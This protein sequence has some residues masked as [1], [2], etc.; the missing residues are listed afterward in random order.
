[1]TSERMT[2]SLV[3]GMVVKVG[4][5]LLIGL[6]TLVASNLSGMQ[7][8]NTLELAAIVAFGVALILFIVDTEIRLSAVGERVTAG[9]AQ[10]GKLLVD[11]CDRAGRNLRD[12]F[13]E[14]PQHAGAFALA[15]AADAVV[16][17]E[18]RFADYFTLGQGQPCRCILQAAEGCFVQRE[19][20]LGCRHTP[21][22]HHT[23]KSP[24]TR[25]TSGT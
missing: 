23:T 18:D 1:M 19:G 3:Q 11:G 15:Q 2:R 7:V 8:R 24:V 22:Y 9:F 25:F 16:E 5:P 6:I 4:F 13:I 21:P 20:D 14:G 12:Q 10:I 17:L